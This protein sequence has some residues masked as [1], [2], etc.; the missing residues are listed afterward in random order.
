MP[1]KATLH[2][3]DWIVKFIAGGDTVYDVWQ[4]KTAADALDKFCA[5]VLK[6]EW[7]D[8]HTQGG[9]TRVRTS[10]IGCLEAYR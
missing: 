1:S 4:G 9:V 10:F 8:F 5:E 2:A 6:E 3:N 7:W